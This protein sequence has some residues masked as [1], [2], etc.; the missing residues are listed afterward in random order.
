[1]PALLTSTST[2]PNASYAASTSP[3]SSGQWPTWHACASTRRPSLRTSSA[4]S[5]Q[6]SCL[7]LETTMSAPA[8]ASAWMIARPSPRVPPVISAT[9]PVRSN[10][11]AGGCKLDLREQVEVA[12]DLPDREHRLR[13]GD[14]LRPQLL[15][16]LVGGLGA[17][18][19]DL[20][21]PVE[22]VGVEGETLLDQP[23]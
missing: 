20:R 15:G 23:R 2:R 21:D 7:R 16:D 9:R 3:S 4:A 22:P 5:S 14:L 1:M 19:D 18:R 8:P 11:S 12:D 17:V 13:L 6:A 10:G